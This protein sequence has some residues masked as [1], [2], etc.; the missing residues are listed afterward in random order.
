MFEFCDAKSGYVYNL[1][2]YTMEHPINSLHNM[3]FNDVER[4]C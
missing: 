1:E 3:A 4:L 2:A